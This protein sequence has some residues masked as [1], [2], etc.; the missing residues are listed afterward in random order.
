MVRLSDELE[1][2]RR[3]RLSDFAAFILGTDPVD[4]ALSSPEE[5]K[6]ASFLDLMISKAYFAKLKEDLR[7]A[8][9][10]LDQPFFPNED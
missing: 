8:P 4:Y 9:T 10:W 3:P 7:N 2:A 1:R 6:E 5:V